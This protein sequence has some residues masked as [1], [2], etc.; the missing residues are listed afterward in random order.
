MH[1]IF[2]NYLK[3]LFFLILDLLN[4]NL[5]CKLNNFRQK[6]MKRKI[7]FHYDKNLNLYFVEEKD[8]KIYFPDKLRGINTY[9]YGIF[10]RAL[11]LIKTYN[12]ELINF[13][14]N[15]TIIDCGANYGDLYNWFVYKNFNINYISFEPSPKEFQCLK[16]NCFKQ[17][18]N[19]IAL[20]NKEG[21]VDFYLK[22]DS[23]DSSI[24]LPSSGFT[25]R[26]KVKTNTLSKYVIDNKIQKIK[27]F[28]VEAEGFEPEVLQGAKDVMSKIEYIGVD[29]SPERGIKNETT[30][31]YAI[32][33]LTN[34]NFKVIASDINKVYAKALFKNKMI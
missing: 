30:I 16:L 2:K 5:S 10:D 20:S 6:I 34:H 15:D 25:Q 11:Q 31:D 13:E 1:L 29:G 28:K 18:N 8:K 17:K 23:G 9:S 19:N 22:T 14:N 27:F 26:I 7:F 3:K 21:Q 33:F 32:R 12:L 4:P 24:I